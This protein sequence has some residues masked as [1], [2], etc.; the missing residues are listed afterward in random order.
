VKPPEEFYWKESGKRRYTHCKT[1]H[2]VMT[3][4]AAQAHRERNPEWAR[5]Y[6]IARRWGMEYEEFMAFRA[7][8]PDRCEICGASE[9]DERGH[10]LHL[11]HDHDTKRLRGVL[12][13][14]CNQGIGRLL[15][16]P[17]LLRKAIAYL[18]Q[19]PRWNIKIVRELPRRF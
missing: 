9:A 19:L 8:L 5:F 7:T 10:G 12:C 6:Q 4:P 16:N 18:E 2:Y 1:C 3:K 13:S 17:E 15:D 11:D 14:N